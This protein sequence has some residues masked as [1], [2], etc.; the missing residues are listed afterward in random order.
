VAEDIAVTVL[1]FFFYFFH[2]SRVALTHIQTQGHRVAEDIVGV[3]ARMER[4]RE[5]QVLFHIFFLA[6]V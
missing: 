1:Y 5:L 2:Q 4:V 3:L 6:C